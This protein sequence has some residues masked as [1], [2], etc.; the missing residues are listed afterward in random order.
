MSGSPVESGPPFA[1]PPQRSPLRAFIVWLVAVSFACALVAVP[2][3]VFTSFRLEHDT[4]LLRDAVAGA[5]SGGG[6]PGWSR[7]V[8][9]RVGGC[10]LGLARAVAAFA[11]VPEEARHAL[12]AARCASVGVYQ[13]RGADLEDVR[14]RMTGTGGPIRVEGRDWA[15]VV[16]V[17]TGG[18]SVVVLT[19]A[20]AGADAGALE[21][22]VVVLA[23]G[24]LVVV[25]VE[26]DPEPVAELVRPHLRQMRHE[27]EDAV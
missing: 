2:Y 20:D 1:L 13:W 26:V 11:D 25:S 7:T 24:Q 16:S 22:C 6:E 10:V 9:V 27:A 12:R 4:K 21:L 15:R 5:F 23:E 17:R 14:R 19:P 18:E 8:E 3:A